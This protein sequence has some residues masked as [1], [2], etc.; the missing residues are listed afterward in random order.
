MFRSIGFQESSPFIFMLIEVCY[1]WFEDSILRETLE[2]VSLFCGEERVTL[3][4]GRSSRDAISTFKE[5]FQ[6]ISDIFH[7]TQLDLG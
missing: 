1:H 3:A 2:T 4:A 7:P 6:I 5:E